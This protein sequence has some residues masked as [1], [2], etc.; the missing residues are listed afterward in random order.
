M[1]NEQIS[2]TWVAVKNIQITWLK[3]NEQISDTL[4]ALMIIVQNKSRC[5]EELEHQS[6]IYP[7]KQA[8]IH[9]AE[10]NSTKSMQKGSKEWKAMHSY[11]LKLKDLVYDVEDQID[12]LISEALTTRIQH[13]AH[14]VASR[15][16]TRAAQTHTDE[17]GSN[18]GIG[19]TTLAQLVAYDEKVRNRFDVRIWV[20]VGDY[21]GADFDSGKISKLILKS[22][23][24]TPFD[25]SNSSM[26]LRKFVTGK[27]I[28]LV[29][30]H[31]RAD[32]INGLLRWIKTL[33]TGFK[34]SW[35]LITT[36]SEKV[37]KQLGKAEP[38][39]LQPL[40]KKA[41]WLL[42]ESWAFAESRVE[43][44]KFKMESSVEKGKVKL[45]SWVEKGEFKSD[46]KHLDH[47]ER[48]IFKKT[49]GFPLFA[50][51][52]ETFS[53]WRIP[54]EDGILIWNLRFGMPLDL[55]GGHGTLSIMCGTISFGLLNRVM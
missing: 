49:G 45:E 48:M 19:K 44:G 7:N 55:R 53:I 23:K 54:K 17:Q 3:A 9:E 50:R 43:K 52:G 6:S 12:R 1:A 42:C 10:A 14:F 29:L 37:A 46:F 21:E 36:R 33:Q 5:L 4:E 16:G 41:S 25:G 13:E 15:L 22:A 39:L 24:L 35:I 34:G 47:I 31:V 26:L 20:P 30:D 51:F 32:N 2:D 11:F 40:D 18:G 38:Y 27:K 8:T 28:L